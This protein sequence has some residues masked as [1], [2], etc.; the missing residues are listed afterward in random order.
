MKLPILY[1]EART[2]KMHSWECWT[3]GATIHQRY[4]TVDGEKS[5]TQKTVAGKNIGKKNETTPEQQAES[6]AQA[7]WQK[8]K[9]TKYSETKTAAK[10]IVFLPMLAQDLKKYIDKKKPVPFK[11]PVDAQP[12]LNGV[13]CMAFWM[14][15]RLVLMSRGGKEY[16]V[17]HIIDELSTILPKDL[18]VDGELYTHSVALQDII[19]F[20]K[21]PEL[22]EHK[23]LDFRVFDG[24]ISGKQ[25]MPWIERDK[26]IADWFGTF[27]PNKIHP[28]ECAE[29]LNIEELTDLLHGWEQDGY[30]GAI[31]RTHDG[32][33]ELGHR[34]RGLW[35]WKS[36][37]DAEFE[38]IGYTEASGND[39]GTVVWCCKAETGATFNVR[40]KG[41]RKQRAEWFQ[42]GSSYVGKQ[43]T[44]KF[45]EY[46]KDMIPS[47]PVGIAIR[48]EGT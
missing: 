34:S 40:P 37:V 42:N 11:F 5:T 41:T 48:E 2:G 47:F 4:G 26:L 18:V 16:N 19:H 10:E 12:K 25:N 8:K 21:N 29:V 28:L 44:V 3:E 13:R 33:Y 7:L 30:E 22:E 9:D 1:H 6:E 35:K 17:P 31:I 36:F 23:A 45:Q 43:L 24:F 20:I 32:S 14:E 39:I 27:E 38:I 46:T 15:D